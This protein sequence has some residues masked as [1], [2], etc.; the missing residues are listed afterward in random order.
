MPA[1]PQGWDANGE[2]T[3]QARDPD[4]AEPFKPCGVDVNKARTRAVL[5]LAVAPEGFTIAD[6]TAKVQS[7]TVP[8]GRLTVHPRPRRDRT[9][10]DPVQPAPQHLTHLNHVECVALDGQ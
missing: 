6:L 4:P 9:Q 8:A 1:T 10:P 2:N 3:V 7:L 5:A